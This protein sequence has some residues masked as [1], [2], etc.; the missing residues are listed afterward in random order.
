MEA[1]GKTKLHNICRVVFRPLVESKICWIKVT[2]ILIIFL[3]VA[4]TSFLPVINR[5]FEFVLD[6]ESLTNSQPCMKH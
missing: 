2:I 4:P 3:L 6:F 5:V 1:A